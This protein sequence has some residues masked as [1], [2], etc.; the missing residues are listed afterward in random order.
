MAVP[1]PAWC[2]ASKPR[3]WEPGW[4]ATTTMMMQTRRG[5][6][7][8]APCGG[9]TTTLTRHRRPGA[10]RAARAKHDGSTQVPPDAWTGVL[11]QLLR[12]VAEGGVGAAPAVARCAPPSRSRRWTACAAWTR[13]ADAPRSWHAAS[14]RLR[15][16]SWRAARWRAC[17]NPWLAVSARERAAA[18]AR[19]V[20]RERVAADAR[21]RARAGEAGPGRAAKRACPAGVMRCNDALP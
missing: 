17:T 2:A 14:S 7:A 1:C 5:V 3:I 13:P 10:P 8:C 19:R 9:C 21:R 12:A 16:R 6:P 4:P 18:E 11:V 20:A 15:R